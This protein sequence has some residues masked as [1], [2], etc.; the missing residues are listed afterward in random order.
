MHQKNVGKTLLNHDK[1]IMYTSL[2]SPLSPESSSH[3]S[4]S[5][6]PPS[7][8]TTESACHSSMSL[9]FLARCSA[10]MYTFFPSGQKKTFLSEL[11]SSLAPLLLTLENL[12]FLD[13][14]V[15]SVMFSLLTLENLLFL[16]GDLSDWDVISG[17]GGEVIT[18]SFCL[19][20]MRL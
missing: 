6:I 10:K 18:A 17:N 13:E 1:A 3:F 16:N 12:P 11:T 15:S 19:N 9:G 20:D 5:L 14:F 7:A 8:L 2:S 4:L